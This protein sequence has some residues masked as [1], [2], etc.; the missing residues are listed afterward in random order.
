VTEDGL[1]RAVT[2]LSRDRTARAPLE[3][4]RRLID[5]AGAEQVVRRLATAQAA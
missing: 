2:E 3:A 5:G 4:G 1:T